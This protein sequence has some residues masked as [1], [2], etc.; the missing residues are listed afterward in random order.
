MEDKALVTIPEAVLKGMERKVDRL[1]TLMDMSAILTSTLDLDDLI[2][3]VMEKAKSDLDAEA[4]SLLFYNKDTDRLEFKGAICDD[5]KTSL[6]PDEKGTL[7][8]GQGIAGWVATNLQP[9]FLEDVKTDSRFNQEMERF[10]GFSAK[11]V[12]AAPL[13]GRSGL[14]GV[15]EILNPRNKDYDL[16][17]VQL[18]A[19]QF[20]AAIENSFF[21]KE[22]VDR[23][24]LRQELD[25]ASS[26]QRSFLPESSSFRKG[27]LAIRAAN[28]S[29]EQ[30]GGD[31][32]DVIEQG[33]DKVGV[34]IG[35]VS[36]KG[37]SAAIY[38]ARFSSDFRHVAHFAG[39]PSH[40]LARLNRSLLK[41]PRGMFLTCIYLRVHIATGEVHLSV[42]GHP[43][44]LWISKGRVKVM[45]VEAGPPLGIIPAEYPA[46]TMSLKKGD[47]LLLLTD[48][49]FEAKN[50]AGQRLGFENLVRFIDMHRKEK[51]F[52]NVVM[53]YVDNFSAGTG[54]SDDITIV[55]LK[56]G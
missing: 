33:E 50:R 29:A 26:L 28:I 5:E 27:D 2:S 8:M 19:R 46:T 24:R 25:I 21:Y 11:S 36:G 6:R 37:I 35:D 10:A 54:R 52:V 31:L 34:L 4:C 12:I 30:V 3:L 42:A 18:L 39:S 15:I 47:R 13:I 38:M 14:I 22:S 20:A 1:R 32:Y 43:P 45:S 23:E 16:E 17:L 48:G 44:F 55:E 51:E 56:W 49:V 40:T 41:S 9:V 53:E 7:E